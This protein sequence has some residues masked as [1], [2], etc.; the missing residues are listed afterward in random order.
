ALIAL[1][2]IVV[3]TSGW[4]L[5]MRGADMPEVLTLNN[6]GVGYMEQFNYPEA[7]Q[8]F[9]QVVHKA[10]RWLP[11]QINLAIA[12]LNQNTPKSLADAT[13]IL[14]RVL[15]KDRDNPHAHYCL[16]IILN[17]SGQIAE[18]GPHFEAVTRIDPS[19]PGGW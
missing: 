16:G 13:E 5:T 18:A 14:G 1:L 8:S 9:R 10:P 12:L 3:A 11:G 2:L 15:V 19:D 4:L 17:Q 6:R 7:E